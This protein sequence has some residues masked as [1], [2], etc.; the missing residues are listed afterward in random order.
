MQVGWFHFRPTS[1]FASICRSHHVMNE[2]F[3]FLRESGV[4]SV[5]KWTTNDQYEII[6]KHLPNAQFYFNE[7]FSLQRPLSVLKRPILSLLRAKSARCLMPVCFLAMLWYWFE[8]LLSI[9]PRPAKRA[10]T[11]WHVISSTLPLKSSAKMAAVIGSS[12]KEQ[13]LRFQL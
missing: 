8:L 11:T 4:S 13:F 5:G 7:T 12:F 1:S 10:R 3:I 9:K 2:G 6:V